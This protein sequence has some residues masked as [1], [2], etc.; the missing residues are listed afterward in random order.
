MNKLRIFFLV[1]ALSF[2]LQVGYYY[3][4][5]YS[6]PTGEEA[7][8]SGIAPRIFS[9]TVFEDVIEARGGCVLLVD[10]SHENR[11]NSTEIETLVSK[12][13]ARGCR[14]REGENDIEEGLRDATSLLVVAP[15]EGYKEQE[16]R[17]ISRFLEKGGS[18]VILSDATRESQINSLAVEFEILFENDYLY[19]MV[20]NDGNYRFIFIEEFGNSKITQG[21]ERITLY[22]ASSISS[23]GN[24]IAFTDTDTYS[25][26]KERSGRFSTA[27]LTMDQKVLGISDITFLTPPHN[28]ATDNDRFV[29]NIA[30]FLAGG[31]RRYTLSDFPH[32]F[33]ERC[34]IV[35]SDTSLLEGAITLRGAL[36]EEGIDASI[37]TSI[38]ENEATFF[39]GLFNSSQAVEEYLEEAGISVGDDKIE[40]AA[41]EIGKEGSSILYLHEDDEKRVSIV[42]L[43]SDSPAGVEDAI[44]LLKE[45]KIGKHLLEDNLAITSFKR[46]EQAE[47]LQNKTV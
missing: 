24:G 25:S 8:F 31:E 10:S 20:K 37:A 28:T 39:L 15:G 46:P 42:I 35:S 7:D 4:G 19:N 36:V 30:D 47:V 2:L 18:M 13:I 41:G 38:P 12:V 43:L 23:P 9:P 16:I 3:R 29:S 26:L 45:G 27:V 32:V 6:P 33:R 11:F 40:M 21:L 22:T 17:A 14:V 1:L 44:K 5:R 34:V